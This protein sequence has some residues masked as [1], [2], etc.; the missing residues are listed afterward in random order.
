M[1]VQKIEKAKKKLKLGKKLK[2]GLK[3]LGKKAGKVLGS[4]AGGAVNTILPGTGSSV[5]KAINNVIGKSLSG[6]SKR[7]IKAIV[8]N[9]QL[10]LQI[11]KLVTALS[12]LTLK[13]LQVDLQKILSYF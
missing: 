12:L 2:K 4:V 5:T 7:K 1:A 8:S 9:K 11:L 6:K 3:K 10:L 13:V